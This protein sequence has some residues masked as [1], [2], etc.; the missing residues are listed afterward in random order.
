MP[1]K[2]DLRNVSLYA[3]LLTV[4]LAVGWLLPNHYPPWNTF[5]SNAWIAGVLCVIALW[6]TVAASVRLSVLPLV[7]AGVAL[8]PWLQ[9]AAGLLPL[10]DSALV[11]SLYM[12]G[13]AAALAVGEQWSRQRPDEPAS[14]VL[15]AAA[16]AALVSVALQIYQWLGFA[17]APE[18]TDI[19]IF[20]STGGRPYANLGQPNQLASLLLWGLLGIA[21]AWHKRW[22]RGWLATG[23]AAVILFGVAL[24]ESRT[25]LLTLTLCAMGLAARR[26]AFIERRMALIALGLYLGYVTCLFGLEPL[27]RLAGKPD[28]SLTVFHRSAGELRWLLWDMALDAASRQPWFGFGWGQ[29]NEAYLLVHPWHPVPPQFY[30]EQS[31]NLLLDLVLWAGWPL[32]SV[33][34]VA[35]AW[36]FWRVVRSVRSLAQLITTAALAVMLVHAMLELPLHHGYFLWPFGLLAGAASAKLELK[37]LLQVPRRIGAAVIVALASVLV[38]VVHDYLRVESAFSELRFQLQ[39]IGTGHDETPPPTLLLAEWSAFIEMSRAVPHAGM[40]MEEIDHWQQLLLY[41]TSPLAFRKVIAALMLNGH[42]EQARFWADRACAVMPPPA[43]RNQ[44]REWEGREQPP[45]S[46]AGAG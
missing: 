7:V 24:T 37:P 46:A 4:A 25:A 16:L 18:L 27:G 32:A 28:A 40:S 34:A 22:L 36:W 23:L 2:R 1:F 38:I 11:G 3:V 5:H 29:T 44:L 8:V 26:P 9:Y 31:H 21:L 17:Q 10:A 39:R 35:G 14:L 20:P 13:L 41:N 19:W 43:C 6:R 33:L 30:V 12:L 45:A 15:S 42:V